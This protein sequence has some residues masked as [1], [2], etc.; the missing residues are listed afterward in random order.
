VRQYQIVQHSLERITLRLAVERTLTAAEE[1][2][3]AEQLIE[4]IGHRFVVDF[5]YRTPT[6]PRGPGGK[7]E[8]FICEIADK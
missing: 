2:G 7:F 3:L 5:D 6:I 1:H 8:D 4:F